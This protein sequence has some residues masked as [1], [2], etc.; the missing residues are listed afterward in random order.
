[1]DFLVLRKEIKMATYAAAALTMRKKLIIN[2]LKKC[3]AT[4]PETAK[5]LEE[6]GIVN[7]DSFAEFTKSLVQRGVLGKTKEGKYWLKTAAKE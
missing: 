1:M 7:P 4:T 6:A 3:G 2:G 5:S